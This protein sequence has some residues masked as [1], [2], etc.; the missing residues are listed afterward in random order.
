MASTWHN[1]YLDGPEAIFRDRHYFPSSLDNIQKPCCLYDYQDRSG[2]LPLY[3][4]EILKKRDA[5][6]FLLL[7]ARLIF[8]FTRN[9]PLARVLFFLETH[10]KPLIVGV[11]R[12]FLSFEPF[13]YACFRT[14][15]LD[16]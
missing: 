5:R 15:V 13:K 7:I 11:S 8:L 4:I 12:I 6:H 2:I 14:S 1:T 9:A 3:L 16:Q 10:Y